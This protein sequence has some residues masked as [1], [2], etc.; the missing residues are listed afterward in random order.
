MPEE[1]L[2]LGKR[3]WLFPVYDKCMRKNKNIKVLTVK[4]FCFWRGSIMLAIQKS[5]I[6]F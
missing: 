2:S 1:F 3:K 5:T 6:A 4:L